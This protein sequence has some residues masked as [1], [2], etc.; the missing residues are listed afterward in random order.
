[1]TVSRNESEGVPQT[2]EREEL[3]RLCQALN[4]GLLPLLAS[5]YLLDETQAS[6]LLEEG[7]ISYL[8]EQPPPPD[9]EAWVTALVLL[10]AEESCPHRVEPAPA[11]EL[12]DE[13]ARAQA[14]VR[15][16]DRLEALPPDAQRALRLRAGGWTHEDIAADLNVT[17][18][19]AKRLVRASLRKRR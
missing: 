19:Y 10:H 18:V 2:P 4:S 3:K 9:A 13:I 1:M 5:R 7:C 16:V 6:T 8:Q 11:E 14:F 12:D 17:V 15:E